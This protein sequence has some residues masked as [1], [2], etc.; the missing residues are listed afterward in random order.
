MARD[1]RREIRRGLGVTAPLLA[2]IAI[3]GACGSPAP[4]ERPPVQ[5]TEASRPQGGDKF[6][7]WPE[8][9]HVIE[10]ELPQALASGD[11][12]VVSEKQTAAGITGAAEVT[13]SLAAIDKELT[14][15]WKEAIPARLDQDNNSPR[16]EIAV[17]QVQRLFLDPEDYVVPTSLMYCVPLEEV[18]KKDKNKAPSVPGTNCVLGN[19]SV[20]LQNVTQPD[21]LFEEVRFLK[22]PS[23][24]YFMANIGLLTFLVSHHD[25]KPSNWLASK[26][27]NRR[28]VFV[29]DN[30]VSFRAWPHNPFATNWDVIRVPA[31]RKDSVDRLR[32]IKREDLDV[33]GVVAQ[34]ETND[35]GVFMSVPPGEN[36]DPKRG[37]R[38]SDGTVQFG[39]TTGELGDLWQRIQQVIGEVDDGTLPV[40]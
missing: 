1:L 32:K 9:P 38:I 30:G 31:F 15:K 19:L 5:F 10:K 14:F 27:E 13:L 36:L 4:T 23:Y 6:P 2:L 22:D 21:P 25:G 28:Q 24:A 17:Y 40:F 8:H 33:L 20:W 12:K 11:Y 39:L 37:V 29:V 18:R 16:R 3:L 7:N 35:D 26:E 34:L